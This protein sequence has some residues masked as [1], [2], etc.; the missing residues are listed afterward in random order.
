MNKQLF[1]IK[2]ILPIIVLLGGSIQAT[3]CQAD[4]AVGGRIGSLGVG[5]DIAKHLKGG[6]NL[7]ISFSAYQFEY[8]S[9]EE[10]ISYEFELDI[11]AT[12]LLIDWH[13]FKGNM[14]VTSGVY[15]NS[16]TLMGVA[17][18]T[19]GNYGI[20]GGSYSPE[21]IGDLIATID[22]G[23]TAPYIGLGWGYDL[24]ETGIG[25]VMDVGILVQASPQVTM[26]TEFPGGDQLQADLDSEAAELEDS[27][28]VFQLYPVVMFGVAYA[29]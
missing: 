21:V 15:S 5:V 25:F 7:R 6:V 13:P 23:S 20:G 14:R 28:S 4:L 1:S 16:T 29:F 19:D 2:A 9:T 12:G 18:P 26:T 24:R 10:N 22:L 17:T 27:L 3:L 11:G 8:E